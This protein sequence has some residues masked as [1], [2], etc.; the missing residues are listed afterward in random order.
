MEYETALQL[1]Q[2]RRS[3]R[4]FKSDPVPE[5]MITK[6]IDAARWAPSGLNMQPWE[7]VVVT[8]DA[9]RRRIV[10][11][12]AAYREQSK[13]M[14]AA[15]PAWQRKG[16]LFTGSKNNSHDFTQAPVYIL[17][18]GDPRTH[19]GLPMGVQC[20]AHRLNLI[21][22]SSLANA[23][24]YLHL[25]ATSLGLAS[26]WFSAVQTPYAAC[27]IKDLLGIP[28]FMDV[29]DMMVLGFPAI[30]PPGKYLRDTEDVIHWNRS[31]EGDFRSDEDV[32]QFV[33]KA[34]NWN[35]GAHRRAVK[36]SQ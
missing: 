32:H 23:F 4:R 15:R 20:D 14:E 36:G 11:I 27:L 21:Y 16:A 22:Q 18:V 33:N 24:L 10:E 19:T 8:D 25:A 29:Y 6:I 9:L 1:M 17:L 35:M 34:R 26:Q 13:D 31:D 5:E 3:I 28:G 30:T 12:T 2:Q 7:F